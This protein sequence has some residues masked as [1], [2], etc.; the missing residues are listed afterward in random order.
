MAKQR[1][2]RRLMKN[3]IILLGSVFLTLC[4]VLFI[5]TVFYNDEEKI[6]NCENYVKLSDEERQK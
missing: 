6:L 1:L 2:I 4:F 5:I 3:K